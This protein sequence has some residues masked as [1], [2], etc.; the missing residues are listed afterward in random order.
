MHKCPLHNGQALNHK[1]QTLSKVMSIL[2]SKFL[3]QDN[4]DFNVDSVSGVIC[5]YRCDSLDG[6]GEAHDEIEQNA[7]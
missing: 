7:D 1:L 5:M 2:Q 6:F 4:V 3:V